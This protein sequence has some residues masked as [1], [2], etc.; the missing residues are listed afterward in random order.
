MPLVKLRRG[1]LTIPKDIRKEAELSDGNWIDVEYKPEEEVIILKPKVLFDKKDYLTLS[2]KG[3]KLI[4]EALQA[5]K[6][7]D[8]VG[9]FSDIE[10]ALEALK[11]S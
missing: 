5:E 9:P 10:E 4:E 6:N 1:A 2:K 3:K 8:V 11:E 7:G